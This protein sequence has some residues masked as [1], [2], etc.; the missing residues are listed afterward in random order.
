[1]AD[2][3]TDDHGAVAA[4]A[5]RARTSVRVNRASMKAARPMTAAEMPSAEPAASPSYQ[6]RVSTELVA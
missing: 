3:G 5:T 2:T 6:V 4:A 1:M